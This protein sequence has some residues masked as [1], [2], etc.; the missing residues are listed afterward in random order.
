MANKDYSQLAKDIITGIG[1][2]ENVQSVSHCV[3]RVRFVLKD[4]NKAD[5][6]TVQKLKGVMKVI[7]A[8]GQYQVVIGAAVEDVYKSVLAEGRFKDG[9]KEDAAPD[10]ALVAKA[11][12]AKGKDNALNRLLGTV[13]AIFAPVLGVL[14]AAGM[15][16]ALLVFLTLIGALTS[17]SGTYTVLNAIGDA[18]LYFFPVMLG[19]S[20]ARHFGLKDIYGLTIGA[21]L[22]YPTLISAA[23]GDAI[24]TL[25]AGTFLESSVQLTFLG[26]PVILRDYSTTVVPIILIMWATS[27]INKWIDKV[28]PTMLRAFFVPL[29]TLLICVPLGLIIIGPVA[30]V[31]QN[32]ISV[33]VQG[34][35]NLNAGIA[36]LV[37]GSVWSILVMFGLHWAVIPFFAINIAQYGYDIINPLIYAGA[38]ASMGS[39]IGVIIREKN[40]DERSIEIPALIST[41]FGV[42]EPTLYGVLIPRKKVMLTCFLSAGIGGAIAGFSGSKLWAFGASGIFGT[43]C[44]INPAGIDAGF[45][46]LIVGAVVAFFVAMITAMVVGAKRDDE[47]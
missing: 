13:S 20:A 31:L 32:T 16:K 30:M 26:I 6:N 7:H 35:V 2:K 17:D 23:G 47:A 9:G 38:F 40:A 39:V 33:I 25:F 12:E 37:L 4:E 5:D 22:V 8:G 36:G 42:N 34:L 29:L 46:G 44:F 3:T 41:F 28:L 19:W 21:I 14:T 10:D 43:P 24:S 27:Y 45:I 11:K 18:P 15:I 1:G